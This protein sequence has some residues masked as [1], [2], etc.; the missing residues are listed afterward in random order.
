MSK[1]FRVGLVDFETYVPEQKITAAEL[2]K[3][4]NIP[5]HILRDKM[6]IHEKYVGGEEDHAAIMATK[7]SKRLL[8]L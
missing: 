7:A 5:E 6:G 3:E 4:V 2:S 8:N 1:N